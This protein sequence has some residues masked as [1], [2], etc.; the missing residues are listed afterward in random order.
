VRLGFQPI[1][2]QSIADRRYGRF[3]IGCAALGKLHKKSTRKFYIGSEE[4][5][6]FPLTMFPEKR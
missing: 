6:I 4:I 3:F 2:A 1:R 5:L